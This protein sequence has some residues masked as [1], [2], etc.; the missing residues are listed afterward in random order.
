MQTLL[1]HAD[2]STTLQLYTQGSI[3]NGLAAQGE[4]LDAIG[5]RPEMV[6]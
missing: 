2:V 5:L 1:R 4:M 3:E 6:N